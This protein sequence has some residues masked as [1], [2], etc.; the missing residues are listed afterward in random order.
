MLKT[1]LTGYSRPR[2]AVWSSTHSLD[3]AENGPHL[4]FT[5]NTNFDLHL[6]QFI[7]ASAVCIVFSLDTP[8][9]TDVSGSEWPPV[10]WVEEGGRN[11]IQT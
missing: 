1:W 10:T 3:E 8:D 11:E 6:I 5:S 4:L 7:Y 9:V 2:K